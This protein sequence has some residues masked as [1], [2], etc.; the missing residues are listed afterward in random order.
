MRFEIDKCPSKVKGAI[1]EI[2]KLLE[3]GD[4]PAVV[5]KTIFKDNRTMSKWSYF[6]KLMC[7][8]DY[9][10]RIKGLKLKEVKGSDWLDCLEH[11]DYRGFRQW[12][13]SGRSIKAGEKCSYILAPCFGKMKKKWWIDAKGERHSLNGN[14]N[15]PDGT[16][17][18]EKEIQYIKTFRTIPVFEATQT[19]GDEIKYE[20]VELPKNLPFKEIATELGVQIRPGFFDGAYG[21]YD[22]E[23]KQIIL[24]T[25]DETTFL[26]ELAHAVDD[27]ISGGLKGGQHQD[28]EIVAQ[29]SANV[30]AHILGRDTKQITAYTKEYI[31]FYNGNHEAVIKLL[32]RIE[33]VVKYITKDN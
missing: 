25:P 21:A 18:V 8:I 29:V 4:L 14:D 12:D 32:S 7:A 20:K 27:K 9:L 28:Q 33:K 17:I 13:T 11:M 6:N 2:I 23:R 5:E 24:C 16:E 1:E 26:H 22:K 15:A 10:T 30:L 31:E 3:S 19:H